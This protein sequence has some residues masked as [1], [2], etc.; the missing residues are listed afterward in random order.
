MSSR[1]EVTTSLVEGKWICL[2]VLWPETARRE[3]RCPLY[4]AMLF[5]MH[6][7]PTN[8]ITD[9]I[10]KVLLISLQIQLLT[11]LQKCSDFTTNSSTDLITKVLLISFQTVTDLLHLITNCLLTTLIDLL[12]ISLQSVYLLH[13]KLLSY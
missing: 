11:S 3:S 5:F 12:L 9:L 1:D 2:V 6:Q 8:S 7:V 13:Y 10:T 4:R